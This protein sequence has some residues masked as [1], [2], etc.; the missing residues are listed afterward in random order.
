MKI[1]SKEFHFYEV[2][3]HRRELKRAFFTSALFILSFCAIS[4]GQRKEGILN[5]MK[6]KPA[7]SVSA[8]GKSIGTEQLSLGP[9]LGMDYGFFGAKATF[10]PTKGLGAMFGAGVGPVNGWW[11]AAIKWR[12]GV[13]LAKYAQPTMLVMYGT[14]TMVI[15][16]GA[17][18]LNKTFNGLTIGLGIDKKRFMYGYWSVAILIPM[19]SSDVDDYLLL[20]EDTYGLEFE[21]K[22][23]PI[24]FS[25]GYNFI[26]TTSKRK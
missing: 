17:S 18:E 21:E 3:N 1:K 6:R 11:N 22:G 26:L 10:F 24:K 14:N 23:S 25:L 8:N 12:P 9:G 19:F 2:L 5:L 20:M 16:D 4:Q 13:D 15:V 7:R